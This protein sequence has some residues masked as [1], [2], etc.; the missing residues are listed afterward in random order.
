MGLFTS[1]LVHAAFDVLYNDEVYYG[2]AVTRPFEYAIEGS[3]VLDP[4]EQAYLNAVERTRL[5]NRWYARIVVG[6]PQMKIDE[7]N[8]YS[9]A[10]VLAGLGPT[11][12]SVE[13]SLYQGLLAGG[14][15][16]QNW[17][18]EGELFISKKMDF[19]EDPVYFGVPL[20]GELTLQQFALFVNV[21]YVIPRWF[22][23][24]PTKL[25]IHFDGGIGGALKMADLS[26]TSLTGVPRQ[27]GSNR[28]ISF[29]QNLAVGFRYQV[30]ASFLVDAMYKYLFLGKATFGPVENVQYQSL[31]LSSN[32]FFIGATY[33]F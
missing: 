14:Y 5:I 13:A 10:T 9:N 22:S 24:Y 19:N 33:Q 6:K 11:Q 29:V 12:T 23:W 30:T 2:S 27:S 17:G 18:V 20:N 4:D 31:K 16:W 28:T 7:L 1:T 15:L 26:T 25:Q 21:Q 3:E 32:G 8:N